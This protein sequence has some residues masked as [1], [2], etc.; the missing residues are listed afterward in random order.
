M[1]FDE[2]LAARVRDALCRTNGVK[3]QKM[4]GGLCFLLDGNLLV[5]VWQDSL[6]AR[7]GPD[8]GPAALGEPH[9]RAFDVTGR[10]M[11]NWVMVDPEGVEDDDQVAAWVGRA[12]A[13]VQTLPR[14]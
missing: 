2:D 10:P 6:I 8:E 7:L 9:V 12:T 1:A 13:F 5:G 14:K 3:E 4:F 11:R